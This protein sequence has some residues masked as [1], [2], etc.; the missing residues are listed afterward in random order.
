M[1]LHASITYFCG[2]SSKFSLYRI[3]W[4]HSDMNLVYHASMCQ[5]WGFK[6]PL[7]I[8]SSNRLPWQYSW[9]QTCPTVRTW[10]NSKVLG[11]Y[12]VQGRIKTVMTL[13]MSLNLT[14]AV[15]T[16][17]SSSPRHSHLFPQ[18]I[19]PGRFSPR[20]QPHI[21]FYYIAFQSD[22]KLSSLPSL[23]PSH[24]LV[25]SLSSESLFNGYPN[26]VSQSHLWLPP[27]ISP[28]CG[29]TKALS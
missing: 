24:T 17:F 20:H 4:P 23:S 18:S 9:P 13:F 26:W 3:F 29:F 14:S 5:T 8:K 1:P 25:F 22:L 12:E 19:S 6:D 2:L 28:T 27:L 11:H 15:T 7:R 16:T 10:R 21:Y